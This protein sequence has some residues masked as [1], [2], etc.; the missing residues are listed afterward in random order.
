MPKTM[1]P[2]ERV[3]RTFAR[4]Q[5]DNV[6][7][8]ELGDVDEVLTEK[9][10]AS[11]GIEC[12]DAFAAKNSVCEILHFDLV[13]VG[14]GSPPRERI[15]EDGRGNPVFLDV[16]GRKIVIPKDSGGA[17]E[18]LEPPVSTPQGMA[19]Y[20]PPPAETFSVEEITRWKEQTDFFV[21][22][23][24]PAH[25]GPSMTLFGMENFLPWCLSNQK[26]VHRWME[27]LCQLNIAVA[28][29]QIEAGCDGIVFGDDMAYNQGT[30]VS[31]NILR[32][33]FFPYT[34][35]VIEFIKARNVPVMLHSD[36]YVMDILPDFID[37]GIDGFQS[38]QPSAGM[39]I[40]EMK[41]T[42][43]HELVL[44][45][46]VDIDLLGR[47]TPEQVAGDVR[48]LIDEI[49]PGGG[50]ILS[51]SNALGRETSAENALAMYET[52]EAYGRN[53]R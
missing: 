13:D 39:D 9:L 4:Q 2:R 12:S 29:R 37:M 22:S 36:G 30:I 21:F 23:C 28:E 50:F 33:L 3:L 48:R 17:W 8:G 41:K 52:A 15:G 26:E 51:S 45:G 20:V 27:K 14:L 34:R 49:A 19:E 38:I 11:K 43:G 44:M 47:G 6:P 24:V 1:K 32:K 5:T 40:V 25:F 7:K 46:N 35:K 42:Y 31:P 53:C 18:C 10:L 16:W